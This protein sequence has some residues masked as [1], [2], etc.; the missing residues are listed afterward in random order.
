MCGGDKIS[1]R[2]EN[3]ER[4]GDKNSGKHVLEEW[5]I[6]HSEVLKDPWQGSEWEDISSLKDHPV[7]LDRL[8]NK[9]IIVNVF[10]KKVSLMDLSI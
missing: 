6:T 2:E 8:L 10:K 7:V 4:S 5:L 9:I 3:P 1:K